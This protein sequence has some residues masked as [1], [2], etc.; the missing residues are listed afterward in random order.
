[1]ELPWLKNF[2][3]GWLDRV[4]HGRLP[5]AV[6]LAGPVGVGKRAAAR[7]IVATKLG[8]ERGERP[9]SG[10][11]L[12]EHADLHW[13]SI[14]ED[15]SSIGIDQIRALVHE[16]SL[17]SY[18]G[19]GKVAVIEP[20]NAMTDSA[21]NSLL[22]TLEEPPGDA[23]L[24]LVADRIGRLPATIFSRCQRID[25]GPPPEDQALAWLDRLQPGA[26]WADAL[27]VAGGAPLLAQ[28]ALADLETSAGLARDLNALG[29]GS[30]S[31]IAVAERWA[32]LGA[33]FVLDWLAQ[34]VKLA[35]IA[36]SAGRDSAAGLAID[37]SVLR[38]MDSRNL[39]CYL[40]IINRLRGQPG[41]SFNVQLT[42][43][44]LL[45]DWADGLRDCTTQPPM[46]GMNQMLAGA[47]ARQG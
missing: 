5:H 18:Q 34:Q 41:G 11:A 26:A 39:F 17:T 25:L 46:D 45:I 1:M 13:I 24:I 8:L 33:G 44:G 3:D 40:D 16:L 4:R 42:L 36:A 29:R 30:G 28:Q 23:L 12:P 14:P 31:A 6:L 7:W 35:L 47:R 20:A 19:G 15:K 38:R 22:K 21:A 32:K 10:S 27:R 2:A 37:E 9:D 43:E